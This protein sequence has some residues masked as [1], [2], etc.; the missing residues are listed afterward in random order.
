MILEVY[1][2]DNAK[3]ATRTVIAPR[4]TGPMR[5][6]DLLGVEV[7]PDEN[8]EWAW[9]HDCKRGSSVTGY[10]IVRRIATRRE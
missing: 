6:G 8:V 3:S 9:S 7:G 4:S 5:A 2:A 1:V 10:T